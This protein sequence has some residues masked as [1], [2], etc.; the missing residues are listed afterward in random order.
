MKGA[1]IEKDMEKIPH[2]SQFLYNHHLNSQR[3]S[4]SI[5]FK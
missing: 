3:P 1:G 4:K 2:L 5:P